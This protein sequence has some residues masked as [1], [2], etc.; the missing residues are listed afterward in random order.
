MTGRARKG[1]D[2]YKTAARML[3]TVPQLSKKDKH[4]YKTVAECGDGLGRLQNCNDIGRNG[5]VMKEEWQ[6]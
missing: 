5:V 4:N 6:A 3:G 2:G 1:Q